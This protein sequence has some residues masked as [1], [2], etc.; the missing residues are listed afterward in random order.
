MKT[1]VLGLLAVMMLGAAV[2]EQT[3]TP[4]EIIRKAE[5]KTRGVT[6]SY[7][8]MTIT[9][10]RKRWSREMSMK[11]WGLGDDFS[12]IVI[13]KPTKD[14]GTATLKRHK[15][16]WS[17]MPSIE[18]II[19]LPPS[20]MGQSWMGT[21]LTN[22]D[23]VKES[24]TV[25]DYT[26]KLLKDTTIQGKLCYKIQ[27]TPK[28]DVAVVWGRIVTCVDKVDFIQLR[29]EMYDEDDFLVNVMNSS[30]IKVM[31]G[32]KMAT[33]MEFVPVE[34]EGQK[35]VMQFD[36]LKFDIPIKESFFTTQNMKRIS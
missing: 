26:H 33:K 25:T 22:D 34:K 10:V 35:T 3:L 6:S 36:S 31:D 18:R 7:S 19:K 1:F 24:S 17:W 9:T 28:E 4:K 14:K 20:M 21:D 8:E 15:E 27:L 32:V 12:L 30:S 29:S 23:L 2:P 5:A 13:T 16:V 11:S